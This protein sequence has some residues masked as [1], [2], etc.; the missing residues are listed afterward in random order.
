MTRIFLLAATHISPT[1]LPKPA[2][3]SNAMQTAISVVLGIVAALALLMIV[4]SGLRFI[5]SGGDPQRANKA[6]DGVVYALVGLALALTA[7]AIVAFV[8]NRV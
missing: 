6:R 3:D 5:T 2:A 1:G 7:E 8:V 4:I